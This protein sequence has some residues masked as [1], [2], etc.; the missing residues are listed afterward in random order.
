MGFSK[1][2]RV[3]WNTAQ[4]TTHGTVQ[5][6]HTEDLEF[7]G[8]TFRAEDDDPVYVVK[9]EKSGS[10]AAH[11]ESALTA[12]KNGSDD[13][14]GSG[15]GGGS[16]KSDSGKGGGEHH[17]TKKVQEAAQRAVKWIEEGKAGKGF[18]DT[19]EHRAH[20]LA[21][22]EAVGDEVVKKMRAYF[23]RHD[24]DRSA[25]GFNHGEDGYPSPG[26]VAWDAWGGDAGRKWAESQTIEG[27]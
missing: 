8:Q 13:D 27:D 16:G 25:E 4:G 18:T 7:K 5:S 22:G 17:P 20:Q 19:G 10:E 24:V 6:K 11:K 26:R 1:G 23:K 14:G 21:E 3:A 12:T 9:S 15:K 2:D